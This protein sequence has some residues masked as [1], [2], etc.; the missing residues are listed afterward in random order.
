MPL[1]AAA[2][3]S[4]TSQILPIFPLHLKLT[5]LNVCWG[6]SK[7]KYQEYLPSS[8]EADLDHNVKRALDQVKT[9]LIRKFCIRSWRFMD[10]YGNG[11]DSVDAAWAA[12]KYHGHCVLPPQF[13][14]DLEAKRLK[15]TEVL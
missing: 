6:Y 4:S 12:K 2:E 10:A 9:P 1:A 15:N 8:S 11:L 14:A 7:R 3:C 13:R 5:V